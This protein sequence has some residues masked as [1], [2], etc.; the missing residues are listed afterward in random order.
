MFA[1]FHNIAKED[2]FATCKIYVFEYYFRQFKKHSCY[3][4][5]QLELSAE[6]YNYGCSVLGK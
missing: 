1:I 4:S 5:Y 3:I 6:K 2:I